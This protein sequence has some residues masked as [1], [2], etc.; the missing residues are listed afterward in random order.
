MPTY[1]KNL[2]EFNGSKGILLP[3]SWIT[4]LEAKHGKPVISVLMDESEREIRLTPIFQR[5][6]SKI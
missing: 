5:E 2:Q 1:T 6:Q 3:K 4:K